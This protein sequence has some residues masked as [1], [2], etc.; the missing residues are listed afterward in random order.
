MRLE[1]LLVSG[2]TLFTLVS[3]GDNYTL[4]H[5]EFENLHEINIVNSGQPDMVIP[6]EE[7]NKIELNN[8]G[9]STLYISHCDHDVDYYSCM[10]DDE[11]TY[12]FID[13]SPKLLIHVQKKD[14]RFTFKEYVHRDNNYTTLKNFTDK[15]LSGNHDVDY[16]N[17]MK[18]IMG[19]I[20]NIEKETAQL[21]V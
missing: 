2:N 4:R 10:S 8:D 20:D 5:E 16:N 9:N 6:P 11:Y 12:F 1:S 7:I 15:F 19:E 14:S 17:M 3:D 13:V 18:V 21:S